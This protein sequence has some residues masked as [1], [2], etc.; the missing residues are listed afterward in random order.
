MKSVKVT[1]PVQ[2]KSTQIEAIKSALNLNQTDSITFDVKPGVIAGLLIE[3]DG[4]AV[5]MTINR[6]LTEIAQG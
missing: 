3:V 4:A 5:D 2:L 6:Q 1:S